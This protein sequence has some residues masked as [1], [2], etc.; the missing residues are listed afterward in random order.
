M[1]NAINGLSLMVADHTTYNVLN[2]S[3]F[4]FCNKSST[5]IKIL[6]WEDNGFCLWQKRLEKDRFRWP[7]TACDVMA[8]T[9]QELRWLLDGLDPFS[10]KGHSRLVYKIVK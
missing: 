1:R 3:K 10:L 8:L 4:I 2:G 5:I 9:S 6:Y 7:R